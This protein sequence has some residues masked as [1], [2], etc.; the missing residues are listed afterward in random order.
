MIF[1]FL[2]YYTYHFRTL[3]TSSLHKEVQV[4]L[5]NTIAAS[6]PKMIS[7]MLK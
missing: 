5:Y 6:Q 3:W 7:G 2:L 1:L 4:K